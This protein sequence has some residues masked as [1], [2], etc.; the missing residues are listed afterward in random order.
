[1]TLLE[2]IVLGLIQGLTEFLPISST[3]HLRIVPALMGLVDSNHHWN[4]PGAAA[5]A[6]IQ[7]GTLVALLIYFRHDIVQLAAAF[8][9]GLV[10]GKPFETF[11]A[12]LAWY[13]VLGTIP[14]MVGGLLFEDLIVTQVRSLWI[15][16][17]ALIGLALILYLAERASSHQRK[18]EQV[19][20]VDAIVM[21][22]AQSLA[23]VPGASRSGTT[24]TA[25]LLLGMTRETAARLSFLLSIPAV[26]GSG[27]YELYKV[28]HSLGAD[29]NSELSLLVATMVSLVSGYAAIAFLMRYLRTHTTY[30]FIWYRIGLGILLI[31]MLIAGK[32]S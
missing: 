24:I 8:I 27:L 23:L 12:R 11:E 1:M 29:L 25:G 13:G 28:H 21:G 6:I 9:R 5:S 14:I 17:A 31:I 7:L 30:I 32:I 18:V 3:A 20:W 19:T 26:A 15:I 16:A 4:D 22:V 10:R 2:A